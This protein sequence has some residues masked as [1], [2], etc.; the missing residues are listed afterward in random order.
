LPFS[1][2]FWQSKK[3][4]RRQSELPCQAGTSK[5]CLF[6]F[7]FGKAKRNTDD[8]RNCR[9]KPAQANVAFFGSFLAKQKGTPTTVGTTVPSR[10]KQKVAFFGSFL[11]KQKGTPTIVGTSNDPLVT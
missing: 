2:P 3:E 7:L 9:A 6:R 4:H 8:S 11:A 5:L 10:H 1:V